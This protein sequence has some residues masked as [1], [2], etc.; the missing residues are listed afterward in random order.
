ML[1]NRSA[2]VKME[3]GYMRVTIQYNDIKDRSIICD[4]IDDIERQMNMFPEVI[5]RRRDDT[6]GSFSVEFGGSDEY[7]CT[8]TCGEFI[9]I[10][11]KTLH[12]TACNN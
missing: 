11:L 8:R 1:N 7:L 5:H 3:E 12:I 6:S 10:L 9:E 2:S 4:T